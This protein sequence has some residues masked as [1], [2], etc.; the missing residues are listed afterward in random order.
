MGVTSNKAKVRIVVVLF[1]LAMGA[2]GYCTQARADALSIGFGAALAGSEHCFDSMLIAQELNDRRWIGYL[3]T[4]GNSSHC[5]EV[6]IRGNLSIGLIRT[7]TLNKW[8]IGA[9][10]ALFE[11]GD[12]VIGPELPAERIQLTGA[13]F[14]RRRLGEHFAV[15]F[16]HNST[17][18][19]TEHNV[20]YNSFTLSWL[21][22]DD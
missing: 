12:R 6:P 16:L 19:S 8:S 11:H 3:N 14:L 7:T 4:H 9:G 2:I 21:I 15:D 22:G 10:F 1:I 20:G 18:G 17:G 5:R 13:L